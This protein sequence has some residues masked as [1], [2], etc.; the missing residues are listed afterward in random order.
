MEV[1][2]GADDRALPGLF[3]NAR[4]GDLSPLLRARRSLDD[5]DSLL[6]APG[7]TSLISL[8]AYAASTCEESPLPWSRSALVGT[9]RAAASAFVSG[10]APSVFVPFG[11]RAALGSD[12]LELCKR[13][14]IASPPPD[15]V[16]SLPPLP[17]LVLAPVNDLSASIGDGEEVSRLIPGSR[18]L[19][20][21]GADNS[22][23]YPEA[24]FCAARAIRRFLAGGQPD[25]C[26]R[27]RRPRRAFSAPPM[28]LRDVPAAAGTRGNA[29]RILA[30]VR[31][32]L[33]D[34]VVRFPGAVIK[35]A[36]DLSLR[37]G[38]NWRSAALRPLRVGGL[39]NGSLSLS[40]T[41]GR[42][43]VRGASY[44]P[45]VRIEGFINHFI[46]EHRD[47]RSGFINVSGPSAIRG[48]LVVRRHVIRGWLGGRYLKARLS[49]RPFT[50]HTFSASKSA[51]PAAFASG[52][53][54]SSLVP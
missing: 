18:L 4:R 20:L 51:S 48:T 33:R 3:R 37:R 52:L 35:R 44:V 6:A 28:S 23:G 1:F 36:Y 15:P 22:V 50:S 9:R 14:P 10:L 32:T 5:L 17:A 13:W 30:A 39:R 46:D 41:S 54:S 8:G 2:G 27:P 42:L 11:P 19:R 45:G 24:R 16:V 12:V 49:G 34:G 40:L 43:V 26:R 21:P 25:E 7:L 38:G 31:M 53:L 29:G 47:R